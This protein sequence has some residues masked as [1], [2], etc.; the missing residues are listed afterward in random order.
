MRIV[1]FLVTLKRSGEAPTNSNLHFAGMTSLPLQAAAL[2]VAAPSDWRGTSS[3]EVFHG[4][5]P[6]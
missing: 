3:W 6:A 5:R 4:T 2:H 1:A